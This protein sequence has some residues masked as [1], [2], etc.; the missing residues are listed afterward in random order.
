MSAILTAGRASRMNQFLR[1][2]RGVIHSAE[3][4][5]VG[6]DGLGYF[7]LRLET[8]TPL[9]AE[10]AALEEIERV[11]RFGV[12][13]E[14]LA[15]AQTLIA[16]EYYHR[17]ETVES[18]ADELALQEALGDW[19]RMDRYLEGIQAVGSDDVVRV[20][21]QYLTRANLSVFEYLPAGVT[22]SFSNDDFSA[23][24][25]DRV[26]RDIVDRS[27]E[28]FPV[29]GPIPM[30]DVEIVFDLVRPPVRRQILRGPDV[31][32]LE[33]H[34][35][36]L[37]SFGIFFPGGR[38]YESEGNAGITE[39]MLRSAL[40]G[41]RRYNTADISRRLENTGARIEVINE[42]DFFGYVL[43]GVSGQMDEALEV[44]VE[45]LQEP[46]FPEDQVEQQ[47]VL[48]EARIAPF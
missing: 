19:Q 43:D 48:Q 36:P 34:R 6:F 22:R 14:E 12:R 42:P 11:Q 8:S 33:D 32:V 24:V 31:Y 30:A 16:Q 46:T 4:A 28:A 47:R 17:L 38:L 2:E 5:F 1:D 15:R 26:P 20:A 7:Q 44:L 9:D 35:L 41:T 40:R 27:I 21:V 3:S 18:L 29:R 39:L 37:V 45:V 10:V 25:L 13:E 23:N